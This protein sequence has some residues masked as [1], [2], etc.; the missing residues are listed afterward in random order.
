MYFEVEITRLF[1]FKKEE[2]RGKNVN[3]Y[4]KYF[5]SHK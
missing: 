3:S 5:S 2:I 1:F 4:E